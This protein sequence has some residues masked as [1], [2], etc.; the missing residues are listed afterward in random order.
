MKRPEPFTR[1][2]RTFT[3]SKTEHAIIAL[4]MAKAPYPVTYRQIISNLYGD[5]DAPN[6]PDRVLKVMVCKIRKKLKKAGAGGYIQTK[7]GFGFFMVE[8]S[9]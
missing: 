6:H 8:L 5:F 3:F 2:T 1:A 9:K 7:Q 4:I